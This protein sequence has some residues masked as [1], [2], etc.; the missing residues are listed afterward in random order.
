MK[1]RKSQFTNIT[2]GIWRIPDTESQPHVVLRSWRVYEL[3]NSDR[4]LV[5]YC[6]DTSEGRVTSRIVSTDPSSRTVTTQSGRIYML[7][8]PS[9]YNGDADYVWAGWCEVNSVV[10]VRDVT[11]EV[12]AELGEV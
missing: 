4:H 2:G 5:G 8:G 11:P 6:D 3:Q 12:E 1:K 7:A 9:G 10:K